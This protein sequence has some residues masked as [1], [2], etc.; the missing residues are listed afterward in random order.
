MTLTTLEDAIPLALDGLLNN[1]LA[2]MAGAG[3]SMAPPSN[4]PSAAQIAAAAKQEY[5]A[6]YTH[7]RDP[8]PEGIEDQAKFFFD[9]HELPVYLNEYIDPDAFSGRPNDGHLAVADLMLSKAFQWVL[10]T[11]VDIL[12]EAGALSLF[13]HAFATIDGLQAAAVPHGAAPLLKVHGCWT[14]DRNN[15]VWTEAQLAE[16]PVSDRICASE[17]WLSTA[18]VDKDLI[19]LGYSTDWDYLNQVIE[20]TLGAVAPASVIVVNPS[21]PAD[22]EASAP[23]LAALA[24][25]ATKGSYY[26]PVSGSTFLDRLRLEFSK[27][28]VRRAIAQ[29]VAEFTMLNGGAAPAGGY[30]D[31]PDE[32]NEALWW[33][34]RDL[35]GC[36]PNKPARQPE[37][38]NEPAVGLTILQIRDAGGV[39]SGPFWDVGGRLVRVLRTP[40][41]F[42]HSLESIYRK[43]MPP[44][45]APDV[46]VAVGAEFVHLLPDLV[47][48]PDGSIA[49]GAGPRWM[50]RPD[51]EAIL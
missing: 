45:A 24:A 19:I 47:R 28:F 46:V 35:L 17:T 42:L 21:D 8:L 1:R 25:R 44:V 18:L 48:N 39:A 12:L 10:T 40:N 27:A 13:G 9:R 29:G 6:R 32:T 41:E 33:M 20:K 2:L 7:V 16:P 34:R 43:D 22:F 3:L 38:Y 23:E 30:V 49:R 5:D 51:F 14:T 50:T 37:P 36:K 4:L 11:N 31:P 15:T 26:V